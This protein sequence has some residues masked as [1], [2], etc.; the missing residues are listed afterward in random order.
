MCRCIVVTVVSTVF[1]EEMAETGDGNSS[2]YPV[3]IPEGASVVYNP[4][5]TGSKADN[6]STQCHTT[7][8]YTRFTHTSF[9]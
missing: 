4:I 1:E 2:M 6:V 7:Y 8:K 5:A 9:Q 3:N